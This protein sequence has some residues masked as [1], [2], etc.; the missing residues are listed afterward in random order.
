[1]K[2]TRILCYLFSIT[3]IVLLFICTATGCKK[4]VVDCSFE[5]LNPETSEYIKPF[6]KNNFGE[7][8]LTYDGE[9][10]NINFKTVRN[11]NG[12][13]VNFIENIDISY[14]YKNKKTGELEYGLPCMQEI[15]EYYL[16]INACSYDEEKY[17]ISYSDVSLTIYIQEEG[18]P[19]DIELNTMYPV[20]IK[21]NNTLKFTFTAPYSMQYVISANNV[22]LKVFDYISNKELSEEKDNT[23]FIEKNQKVTIELYSNEV[24]DETI[25]LTP[26]PKLLRIGEAFEYRLGYGGQCVY[27]FIDECNR[28]LIIGTDNNDVG[29]TIYNEKGAILYV[30]NEDAY[31]YTANEEVYVHIYNTS[32]KSVEGSMILYEDKP[33]MPNQ[34]KTMEL[35]GNET[36][37]MLFNCFES[38]CYEIISTSHNTVKMEFLDKN[39]NFIDGSNLKKGDITFIS[40]KN[41]SS[42]TV[43]FDFIVE[44]S[45]F[46]VVYGTNLIEG[47]ERFVRFTP[48][49]DEVYLFDGVT[50]IYDYNFDIVKFEN[51]KAICDSTNKCYY[52]EVNNNSVSISIPFE[53]LKLGNRKTVSNDG[54]GVYYY[55]ILLD[56]D[57]EYL[58]ES[59]A[60][61]L[62]IYNSDFAFIDDL[63]PNSLI[64]LLSGTYYI[65]IVDDGINAEICCS[66]VGNPLNIGSKYVLHNN[67]YTVFSFS[68]KNIRNYTF[69]IENDANNT[70]KCVLKIC[71]LV[72]GE[73]VTI[74]ETQ[75]VSEINESVYLKN[76]DYY[77]FVYTYDAN[78]QSLIFSSE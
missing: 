19:K 70:A 64:N 45:P 62:S 2:K 11:D 10:K 5:F 8:Y 59:S 48:V 52:L 68:P 60:H 32:Q 55:S 14:T 56:F 33:V 26:S 21:G 66:L 44:F 65:K 72:D 51:G 73:M 36:V 13:E 57:A 40:M 77:V 74:F 41:Q 17:Y 30:P 37:T 75:K 9:Q 28:N 49:S 20:N 38:G 42:E 61:S 1:M 6:G 58:F 46:E 12:K 29:V 63:K 23:F 7:I 16:C 43:N 31:S 15:G 78:D 71:K 76:E 54:Y 27:K 67:G 24:V 4:E 34:I 50:K 18:A 53:T 3:S 35:N 47:G 25:L 22:K 69:I 39:G